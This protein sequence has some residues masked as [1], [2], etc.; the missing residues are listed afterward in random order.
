M[1][2]FFGIVRRMELALILLVVASLLESMLWIRPLWRLKLT[3]GVT[4]ALLLAVSSLILIQEG[5][6]LLAMLLTTLSIY[7]LINIGR[8]IKGRSHDNYLFHMSRQAGL[9][10]IGAQLILV[11]AAESIESTTLTGMNWLYALAVFQLLGSLVLFASTLRHTRTTRPVIDVDA[12]ADR[13]LPTLTVAIPARNETTSLEQCIK[14]LLTSDYPK[15]EILVLDDC[16]QNT[17]TPEIIKQ[18]AQKGVRFLAGKVPPEGWLAKNYAYEQLTT[19]ANGELVLFCGVDTRFGSSAIRQLVLTLETKQK[20]MLSILPRNELTSGVQ[21]LLQPARYAWEISLPRR[22]FN[23]P[24]VLSTC[25]LIEKRALHAAGGFMAAKHTITPE[26]HFAKYAA[27]HQDGY[28][29]LRSTTD[30]LISSNKSAEEQKDTAVRTR[31]PQLHRRIEMVP[32]IAATELVLLVFPFTMALAA[33][34]AGV[35]PLA[36]LST[37]AAVVQVA[38]YM[39]VA[40]LTYNTWLTRGILLVPFVA[41]YDIALIHY[42]M[43]QYEFR[44]VIWKDRNVCIPVMQV[45]PRLPKLD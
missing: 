2:L 30:A 25:W 18:F 43:W 29:F 1:T 16:S 6:A 8:A 13:D 45:V 5:S 7:R 39:T 21:L 26:A 32:L 44:Q 22:L 19:E 23:R 15:L 11:T 37:A 24:P 36:V 42:S 33:Y 3:I 4:V 27:T 41:A 9:W 17:R 14:S 20:T 40:R 35:W 31:Y 34:L 28:S 12:W 10:L 38:T